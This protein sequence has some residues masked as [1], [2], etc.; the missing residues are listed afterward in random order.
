MV[1]HEV[2]NRDDQDAE[3]GGLEHIFPGPAVFGQIDV[4]TQVKDIACRQEPD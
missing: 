3:Q 1:E 4:E 2:E